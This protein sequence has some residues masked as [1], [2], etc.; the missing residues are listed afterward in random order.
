MS[1]RAS[2]LCDQAP[3]DMAR[4]VAVQHDELP[5][6]KFVRAANSKR[7]AIQFGAHRLGLIVIAGNAQHR[8]AE[9]AEDAAKAQIARLVILHQIARDQY[10]GVIRHARK[11]I[12]E[13]RM[14]ARI[15]LDAAQA[16]GWRCR[17]D[18]GSVICRIFI[19]EMLAKHRAATVNWVM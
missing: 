5:V 13:H 15:R 14:Q 8:F 18:A 7:R 17:T 1:R 4:I 9:I 3:A 10:G 11:G 6:A 2:S 12:I 16:A 19:G